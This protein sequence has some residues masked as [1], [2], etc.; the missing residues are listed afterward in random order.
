MKGGSGEPLHVVIGFPG[1]VAESR[2][3]SMEGVH[4]DHA[5]IYQ[6]GSQLSRIH[7]RFPNSQFWILTGDPERILFS[8]WESSGM[9]TNMTFD[10]FCAMERSQLEE[11]LPITE[12]R[13]LK[14]GECKYYIKMAKKILRNLRISTVEDF[15]SSKYLHMRT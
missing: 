2:I 8:C 12:T 9:P 11:G 6:S 13:L 10:R 14:Y 5:L 4:Y 7:R 15:L 3:K 1:V